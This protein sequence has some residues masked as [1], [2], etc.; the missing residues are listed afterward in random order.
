MTLP[1]KGIRVVE[2][3]TVIAAP[4]A[5][6]VLCAYGADVV[7][8]EKPSGDEMRRAGVTEKVICEDY[9]NPLFTVHNSNKK[10]ISLNLKSKEGLDVMFQLLEHA[11]VFISNVR[12][13]SLERMGLDYESLKEKYP[14]LI[15]A[16]F[17]GYGPKG[18]EAGLPGFD[19]TA[20]WMKSG[21]MADWQV[22]GS[23]PMRPSYGFGDMATSS[24]FVS[25]ILMA[26]LGRQQTGKGT[27]V[28]TSLFA[29]GVWCNSSGIV[30]SQPPFGKELRP[31][32]KRP[33][34]PFAFHYLCKDGDW[35][36]IFCNEYAQDHM[37]IAKVLGIEHLY[38]D[39][40]YH[41]L[42]Q[43]HSSGEIETLVEAVNQAFLKKDSTEWYQIFNENNVACQLVCKSKNVYKDPQA[44]EN[45]YVERVEFADGVSAV[46]P[47]PPIEFSNFER[48]EY[49]PTGKIG[50]HTDEILTD[51]GYSEEQIQKLK[52]MKA[53]I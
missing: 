5:S 24:A 4:T 30:A 6:R 27:L 38:T 35:F 15:Y 13:A 20:F 18:P 2:L 25:G 29:S 8:V 31:D 36:G 19:S 3:A 10:L 14:S 32:P 53:L 41:D 11:D 43:L 39:E 34:D 9:K 48:R 12:M 1:L 47:N 37:K 26:I 45:G 40:R 16:H 52:D 28:R 33:P 21:P 42:K 17:A 50:E 22:A 44:L 7:K 46:L 23:R 49:E 51:L